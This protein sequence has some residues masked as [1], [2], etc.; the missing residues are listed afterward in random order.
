ML[1]RMRTT[2]ETL[3]ASKDTAYSSPWAFRVDGDDA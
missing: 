3:P 2:G 1:E